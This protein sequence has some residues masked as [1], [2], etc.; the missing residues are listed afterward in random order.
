MVNNTARIPVICLDPSAVSVYSLFNPN[1]WDGQ[2]RGVVQSCATELSA[3]EYTAARIENLCATAR[4]LCSR[5]FDTLNSQWQTAPFNLSNVT[6]FGQVPEL[7]ILIEGFFAGLKSLLDLVSQLVAT[8]GVVVG[9]AINGFHRVKG[10]YGGSVINALENNVPK[11]KEAI[12]TAIEAVVMKHKA[13]WIDAAIR[14][15]DALVHPGRGMQ[16]L[17]FEIRVE[18]LNGSLSF[19]HAVPP[20]VDETPISQYAPDRV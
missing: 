7:H 14:Y 20:H 9:I 4:E 18:S 13:L 1:D 10:V 17:M 11:R 2:S 8:E 12:A 19:L 5:H 3:L 15:R 16:Q 6:F